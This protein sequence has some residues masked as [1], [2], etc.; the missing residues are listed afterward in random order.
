MMLVQARRAGPA[1]TMDKMGY[2]YFVYL[3]LTEGSFFATAAT[4]FS[5]GAKGCIFVNFNLQQKLLSYFIQ[6]HT[7]VRAGPGYSSL[8]RRRWLLAKRKL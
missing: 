6:S 1:H 3:K 5:Q 4:D 8:R 2:A 7:K